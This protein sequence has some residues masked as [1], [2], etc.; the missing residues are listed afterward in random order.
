MFRRLGTEITILLLSGAPVLVQFAFKEADQEPRTRQV[1]GGVILVYGLVLVARV[2]FWL[3]V[4]SIKGK[5]RFRRSRHR[6]ASH[7]G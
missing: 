5:W 7:P 3:G 6:H 2:I 4:S 1:L